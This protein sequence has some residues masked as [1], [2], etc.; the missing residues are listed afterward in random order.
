MWSQT[1][2]PPLSDFTSFVSSA[3]P[4]FLPLWASGPRHSLALVTDWCEQ[5]RAGDETQ[6]GS[7]GYTLASDKR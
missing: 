6:I 7:F 4:A 1:A 2:A 5:E 3:Y